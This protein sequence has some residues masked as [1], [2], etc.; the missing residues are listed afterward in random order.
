MLLGEQTGVSEAVV[1]VF[2][3]YD[4][5]KNAD[6]EDLGGFD[7]AVRAVAVFPRGSRISGGVVVQEHNRRRGVQQ[8]CLEAFPWLC[9]FRTYVADTRKTSGIGP[10]SIGAHNIKTTLQG[11][12][13]RDQS[14]A[15]PGFLCFRF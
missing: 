6:A 11:F 9:Y 14:R 8:C 2:A 4:V 10:F 13:E 3:E 5:V 1:V 15:V 12:K 7:Q